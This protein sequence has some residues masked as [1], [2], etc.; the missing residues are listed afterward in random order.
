MTTLLALLAEPFGYD[1]MLRAMWTSAL[2]GGLCAA[3]SCFLMLKGWSLVGDA[4]S[5]AVVPG[6]AVAYIACL[7]L[8][9]G[10]LLSAL[11]AAFSLHYF[12]T[13]KELK[14]DVALGL[15][16]VSFLGT[17]LFIASISPIPVPVQTIV[18]GNILAISPTD[19]LQL[20]ALTAACSLTLACLW[21]D[22]LL[23][24]FD[25]CHAGTMGIPVRLIKMLFLVVLSVAIVVAMQTVGAFL[26]VAMVITPGATAF[27]VCERFSRLLLMSVIIG[28]STAC[29]GVYLSYFLDGATGGII[30]VMQ[31]L[32]FLAAFAYVRL[33]K[34][35]RLSQPSRSLP[36][37]ATHD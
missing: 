30:I 31:S 9:L 32:C 11:L 33:V 13:Q 29:G 18:L 1:Y 14:N 24:F 25:E 35:S 19:A 5:H 6:V 28:T 17:G 21:R 20:A 37:V 3:L 36:R 16:F 22:L 26:V 10:A 15:M 4:L 7:P 12:N 8:G 2:V 23:V 34:Q 27:L